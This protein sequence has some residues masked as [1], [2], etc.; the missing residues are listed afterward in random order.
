[1]NKYIVYDTHNGYIKM[2]GTV[3]QISK[4]MKIKESTIRSALSYGY[5]LDGRYSLSML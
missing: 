5:K 3:K 2:I 1:M 4:H